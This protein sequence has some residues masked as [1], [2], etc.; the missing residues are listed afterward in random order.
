[1]KRLVLLPVAAALAAVALVLASSASAAAPAN[2]AAPSVG[3]AAVQGATLTASDGGWSNNPTSFAYQ[4]QRCH[5][6]GTSCGNITGATSKTYTLAA[7]DVGHTARVVVT[8]TN[9]DGKA[10][11]TSDATDVVDSSNGPRNDVKPTLGNGSKA[12]DTI[13]VGN[14]LWTPTPTSFSR[15]WQRCDAAGANCKDIAG[16]T[17]QSYNIAS[18]DV[19][20]R[21]RALVTAHA[22]GGQQAT[23]AT[24]TSPVIASNTTTTTQTTTSVVTT[25][26]T[27]TTTTP[28]PEAPTVKI[29][30]LTHTRTSVNA[31]IRVCSQISGTVRLTERDLK[32]R[33]LPYTRHFSVYVN[34]CTTVSKSWALLARYRSNGRLV[35]TL[36]ATDSRGL[37]SQLASSSTLVRR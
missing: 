8:A 27:V 21:L 9:Q 26:N 1:M 13:T 2:T 6:D 29:V 3:G 18:S 14:G 17:G 10:S 19:G 35:V 30:S 28:A 5:D 16:A 15:Q 34:G 31:R 36:R 20:S 12:G 32:T 7:A 37:L 4:W 22:S 11:A 23:V 24:A 25:T 33:Q